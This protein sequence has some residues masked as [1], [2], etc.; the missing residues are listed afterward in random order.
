[1]GE[2]D[3]SGKTEKINVRGKKGKADKVSCL[4]ASRS[5]QKNFDKVD[6][7][8]SPGCVGAVGRINLTYGISLA[9]I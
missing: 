6:R 2:T 5:A 7:F 1:M 9:N 8:H 4:N 3:N